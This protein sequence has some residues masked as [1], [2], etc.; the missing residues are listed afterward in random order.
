MASA[1]PSDVIG[2]LL[3][4][5]ESGVLI[6]IRR[7]DGEIGFVPA[8]MANL[9]ED[10]PRVELEQTRQEMARSAPSLDGIYN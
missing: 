2:D 9:F 10:R 3:D 6:A 7:E 4:L 1:L 5:L 8:E